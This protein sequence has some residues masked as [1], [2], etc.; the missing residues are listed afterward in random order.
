MNANRWGLISVVLMTALTALYL[1]FT[2]QY[3]IIMISAPEPM[4]KALGIA[5]I[6]FPL[7]A[8]WYLAT[9][10]VFVIR[11]QLLLRRLGAEGGLPVDDLPRLPSGRIDP[12]AAKAEFPAYK[13]AV[14]AE[15]ESWRAWLRLA[16]A[17]DAAG[18]RARARWATR[19]ALKRPR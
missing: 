8:V 17:Y 4:A 2:T 11:G 6:V 10:F 9:E 1:V 19:E 12:E 13:D 15:P 18:D 16:L 5:L 14:E 3:A 7:I